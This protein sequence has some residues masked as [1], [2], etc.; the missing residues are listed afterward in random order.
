[1]PIIIFRSDRV[2]A[3]RNKS[4]ER[5]RVNDSLTDSFPDKQERRDSRVRGAGCDYYYVAQGLL[6]NIC[7]QTRLDEKNRLR[8]LQDII[9]L[10]VFV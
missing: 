5:E 4:G 8:A 9:Q 3:M 1:M 6:F 10:N 7:G 2:Y